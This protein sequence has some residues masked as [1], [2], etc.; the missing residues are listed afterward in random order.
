LDAIIDFVGEL[1]SWGASLAAGI[2]DFLTAQAGPLGVVLAL[3]AILTTIYLGRRTLQPS[4]G[5]AQAAAAAPVRMA[6]PAMQQH[7]RTDGNGNVTI[8]TGGNNNIFL[9]GSHGPDL[10]AGGSG[11]AVEPFLPIAIRSFPGPAADAAGAA[12]ADTLSLIDEFTEASKWRS[13]QNNRQWQRDLRPQVEA[14]LRAAVKKSAKLRLVLDAH[15]SIAFLAG[16]VLD[17]KSGVGL[18]LVQKGEAGPR[19]WRADD[20]SAGARFDV[21]E[22]P[23]G[24]GHDIACVI[25]VSQSAKPQALAFIN[26]QLPEVGRLVSCEM[27]LGPG[28]Q[29]IAGGAHASALAEQVSNQVREAKADNLEAVVHIFAACPNTLLFL[30]GRRHQGIAP[31][32]LY[33]YD[34]DRQGNRT[35]QPSFRI[36]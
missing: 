27:P 15:A 7:A 34:F 10:P 30:L 13:L 33:E 16:A 32:I 31:C 17:L 29:T 26:A 18:E 9:V 23:L 11:S 14:F 22:E 24:D 1:W 21:T 28:Q 6:D 19:I 35:Y 3:V 12:Q 25:S 2:W 36:G 4:S 5:T 20:G 8:Q